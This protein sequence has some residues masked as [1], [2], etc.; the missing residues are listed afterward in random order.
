V[1]LF[2]ED[3]KLC[4]FAIIGNPNDKA[5]NIEVL[6]KNSEE[7][8]ENITLC[9]LKVCRTPNYEEMTIDLMNERVIYPLEDK[10]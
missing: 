9:N 5:V 1:L 2:I 8:V 7:E 6:A 3:K 4:S 10:S